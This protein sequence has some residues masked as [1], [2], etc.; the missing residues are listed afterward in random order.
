MQ[1][2]V[3]YLVPPGIAD[4][5]LPPEVR[6]GL[7]LAARIAARLAQERAR[8]EAEQQGDEPEMMT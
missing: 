1:S 6:V 3:R 8:K 2:R 5:D 4:K 7:R